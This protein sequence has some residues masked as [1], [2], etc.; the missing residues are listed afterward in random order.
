MAA[1]VPA[2]VHTVST[3]VTAPLDPSRF[4]QLLHMQER[5]LLAPVDEAALADRLCQARALVVGAASVRLLA[6]RGDGGVALCG[7][8]STNGAYPHVAALDAIDAALVQQALAEHRPVV[9][10]DDAGA[11]VLTLP[12][13]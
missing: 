11:G 12:V 1:A 9:A 8:Y 2:V 4:E 6:P 3:L 7:S 13:D 10:I 5:L